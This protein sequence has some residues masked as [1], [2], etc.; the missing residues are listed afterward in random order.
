MVVKSDV[1]NHLARQIANIVAYVVLVVVTVC[2]GTI[3]FNNNYLM[4]IVSRYGQDFMPAAYSWYLFHIVLFVFMLCFVIYQAQMSKRHDKVLRSIDKLF[5]VLVSGKIL[6]IVGFFYDVQAIAAV[7]V[8]VAAIC[9]FMI[10]RRI[11]VG[12]DR[13]SKTH[14]WCVHFP[15]SILVAAALFGVV[16][17]VSIFCLNYDLMW[18]GVGQTAW[19]VIAILVLSF[20]GTLFLHYRPDA[21]FGATFVWL[22]TGVA[23]YA[24]NK[25]PVVA[26]FTCLMVLYFAIATYA[27]ALHRPRLSKKD[28]K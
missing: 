16:V 18:W 12:K 26:S 7:G 23:V 19:N 10:Y 1:S 11:G 8:A 4:D 17:Q 5:L 20:I 3:P 22:A 14:Y 9:A 2:A 15:F 28:T 13:V 21:A 6:W 24:D 25:D 27:N